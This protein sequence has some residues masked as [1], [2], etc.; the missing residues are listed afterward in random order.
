[1]KNER[2]SWLLD[3]LLSMIPLDDTYVPTAPGTVG[4]VTVLLFE[5]LLL[6]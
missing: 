1:M 2:H 3:T 5:Y 4:V 6:H